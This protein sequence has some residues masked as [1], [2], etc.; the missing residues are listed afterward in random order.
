M[1]MILSQDHLVKTSQFFVRRNFLNCLLLSDWLEQN[2][3]IFKYTPIKNFCL[4][5]NVGVHIISW[6]K[7]YL[8]LGNIMISAAPHAAKIIQISS[9]LEFQ[10]LEVIT[11]QIYNKFPMFLLSAS[12]LDWNWWF[13]NL[14]ARQLQL[15]THKNSLWTNT[16]GIG[17]DNS[18]TITNH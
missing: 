18:T 5:E 3:S 9:V 15:P 14:W 2:F 10:I 12:I 13:L 1:E 17:L 16:N 8:F 6:F 7:L 4:Y 11:S